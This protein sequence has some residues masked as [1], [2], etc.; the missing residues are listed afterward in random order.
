M[1]TRGPSPSCPS[2]RTSQ[3]DVAAAATVTA[4][5]ASKLLPRLAVEAARAVPPASPAD[6]HPATVHE[7]PF[8]QRAQHAP[9]RRASAPALWSAPPPA[10]LQTGKLMAAVQLTAPKTRTEETA[11]TSLRRRHRAGKSSGVGG[12]ANGG[13]DL[14]EMGLK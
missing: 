4:I 12:M 11:G 1:W 13:A 5:G 6:E 14:T 8:L 9:G 3:D 2:A 7:V 10:R